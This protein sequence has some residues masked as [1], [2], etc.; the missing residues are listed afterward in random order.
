MGSSCCRGVLLA[1]QDQRRCS[2]F[3]L[4]AKYECVTDI[5]LSWESDNKMF[6]ALKRGRNREDGK[7]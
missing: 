7:Q 3:G 1:W 6:V 2:V 4:D 5:C